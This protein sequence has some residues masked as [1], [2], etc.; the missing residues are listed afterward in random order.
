V[1]KFENVQDS[2]CTSAKVDET[3]NGGKLVTDHLSPEIR[4]KIMRAIRSRN[5]K[6]ED[7]VCSK[8]WHRGLRFRRNVRDLIGK[9]DIA[10]KKYKVV[11]FLDSCFWHSCT[12]HGRVPETNQEYWRKKLER[13]QARDKEVNEYYASK[14]WH[15]LRVWEH[16]LK[17]DFDGTVTMIETFIRTH[18]SSKPNQRS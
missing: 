10:I 14:G 8:L 16:D 13:N 11:V 6:M 17:S 2:Y 9:P 3:V 18:S 1:I 12:Q 4:R 15:V 5:T 7:I